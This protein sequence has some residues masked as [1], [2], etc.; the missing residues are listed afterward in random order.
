MKTLKYKIGDVVQIKFIRN[1]R[2]SSKKWTLADRYIG[3]FAKITYVSRIPDD[4]DYRINVISS[5]EDH[6]HD[7]IAVMES[8]IDDIDVNAKLKDKVLDI[9]DI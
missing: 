6:V 3:K 2:G 5:R 1:M 7:R 9:I 8:D 4:W